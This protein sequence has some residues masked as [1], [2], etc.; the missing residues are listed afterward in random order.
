M[1]VRPLA[2]ALATYSSVVINVS[3]IRILK[4][5]HNRK[6]CSEPKQGFRWNTGLYAIKGR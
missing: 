2:I 5:I 6:K 4:A 3:K 1:V